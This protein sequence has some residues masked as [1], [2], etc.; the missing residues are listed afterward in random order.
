MQGTSLMGLF[1]FF[2]PLIVLIV[3]AVALRVIGSSVARHR[4]VPDVACGSCRYLVRGIDSEVCPECGARLR[5]VGVLLPTMRGMPKRPLAT[6]IEAAWVGLIVFCLA[7]LVG[8]LVLLFSPP[9]EPITAKRVVFR[10]PASNAYAAIELTARARGADVRFD[11]I[12]LT[13]FFDDRTAAPERLDLLP[14]DAGGAPSPIAL[15]P[16][17]LRAAVARSGLSVDEPRIAEELQVLQR[18]AAINFVEDAGGAIVVPATLAADDSQRAGMP[19]VFRGGGGGVAVT[20][21]SSFV[22]AA[23]AAGCIATAFIV[24]VAVMLLRRG[25][26]RD[27]ERR[28]N[29]AH[30]HLGGRAVHAA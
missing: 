17:Q 2:F 26:R 20:T 10:S 19:D 30:A 13:V 7:P 5:D 14:R 8:A 24:L 27:L 25:R 1:A 18:F 15:D 23:V 22:W 11:D 4:P 12:M 21:T 28:R 3:L 9:G 6:G 16:A 29:A